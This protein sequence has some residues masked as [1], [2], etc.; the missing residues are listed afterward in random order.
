MNNNDNN[1]IVTLPILILITSTIM[2]MII[3]T[4]NIIM[5]IISMIVLIVVIP[6][7]LTK[8]YYIIREGVEDKFRSCATRRCHPT[9]TCE[10]RTIVSYSRRSQNMLYRCRHELWSWTEMAVSGRKLQCTWGV[11]LHK[12]LKNTTETYCPGTVYHSEVLLSWQSLHI[13]LC[14]CFSLLR[15]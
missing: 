3:I 9:T 12:V 14:G 10:L 4:I 5:I 15:S 7:T 11:A 6:L 13:I 8:S 1:A 2:M